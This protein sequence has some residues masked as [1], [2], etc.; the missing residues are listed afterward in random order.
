MALRNR[1][2]FFDP[3]NTDRFSSRDI[4]TEQTMS[5]WCDSVP[6]IKE[7]TD[8][9]QITR[10]GIA[11]TT[12]DAKINSGDN[13]DA[14]GVS[15]LGFTTFV[16]PAQLPLM[17]DSASITWSKVPRGGATN[18]DTGSGIEDWSGEVQFP[19]APTYDATDIDTTVE[20]LIKSLSG[21]LCD[22]LT[23][24]TTS[25]PAG[26]TVEEA[27]IALQ[28]SIGVIVNNVVS[29]AANVCSASDERVAVGDVVMSVTNPG[30]WT[31]KWLE[32][33]GQS[34]L[35]A[36]YPTLFALFGTT[37]GSASPL[38]FNIPDM[39]TGQN[40]LRVKESVGLLP[41]GQVTGGSASRT[42]TDNDMPDH[43]HTVTGTTSSET[44]EHVV[45]IYADDA[46]DNDQIAAGGVTDQNNVTISGGAHTHTV[47]GTTNTYGQVTP[48]PVWDMNTSV[49]PRFT[50]VYLKMRVK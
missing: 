9:A 43:S 30:G 13:T 33:K 20:L 46:V 49:T 37:Y 19:A 48:D 26:S 36:D 41:A 23:S 28:N 24:S 14:A 17:I 42:L 16:R 5:D 40:Y 15:P 3:L 27:L 18:T 39:V 38:H 22:P 29:I 34:L 10:A 45:D 21:A 31:D 35:R 7:P 50:N 12:T 32:P 1:T 44:H 11:K 8:K 47:T 4:P 25:V 2:Y 6:F